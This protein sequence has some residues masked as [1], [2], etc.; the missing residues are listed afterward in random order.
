[1]SSHGCKIKVRSKELLG[2][3]KENGPRGKKKCRALNER[4]KERMHKREDKAK[5]G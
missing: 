3:D 2:R 5:V 1:V 4:R